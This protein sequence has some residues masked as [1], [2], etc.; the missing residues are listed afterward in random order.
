VSAQF[1]RRAFD[2]DAYIEHVTSDQG[3]FICRLVHGEPGH[4]VIYRDDDHVAFLNRFPTVVGYTLVAPTRHRERVVDDFEL[5]AYLAL[6]TLIHRLGRALSATVPT[7]RL[8]VLSLGSQE[9][10]SHVHWHLA[11]LPPGV[12]YADQQFHALMTEA[13][14]YLDIPVQ[15]QVALARRIAAAM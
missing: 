10:N 5:D 7:E 1:P 11:P 3:C 12:P 8:Y 6:Q 2:L 4:A 15:D 14:G 13:N 9:G